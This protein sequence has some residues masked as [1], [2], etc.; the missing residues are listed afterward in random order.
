MTAKSEAAAAGG[1]NE[2][3]AIPLA[4]ALDDPAA[5]HGTLGA[6]ENWP[7]P[8]RV[9]EAAEE[10]RPGFSGCRAHEYEDLPEV[11]AAKARLVADLIRRSRHAV[12]YTG[13]GISTGAGIK[14]YAT[15]AQ[16]SFMKKGTGHGDE[17][18]VDAFEAQ[19]TKAHRVFTTMQRVG[20]LYHWVQQNHD[21]S[22]D[23]TPMQCR[24]S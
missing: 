13:A 12:A 7:L 22:P 21:G 18:K 6:K 20:L 24:M 19:P 11:V 3:S 9:A 14:D 1:Y 2:A 15:K 16:N 23:L 8:V 10:N 5:W 17:K 4:A